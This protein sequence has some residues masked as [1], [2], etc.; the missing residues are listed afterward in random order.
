M[1]AYKKAQLVDSK[2]AGKDIMKKC[3]E[4]WKTLTDAQKLPYVQI[5]ELD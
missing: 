2:V 5:Y 3:S 1:E 4:T